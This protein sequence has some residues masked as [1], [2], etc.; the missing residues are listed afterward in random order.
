MRIPNALKIE[1][2]RRGLT[3]REVARRTGIA[4]NRLSNLCS[5]YREP[6]P[7][8]VQAL[9]RVLDGEHVVDAR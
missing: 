4:E 1:I 7:E 2:I 6:R 3:Q 9:E 5:G 8:E